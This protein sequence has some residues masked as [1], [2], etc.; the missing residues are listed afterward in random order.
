MR[1]TRSSVLSAFALALAACSS[2]PAPSPAGTAPAT[3]AAA[4]TVAPPA[5]S[6]R[7]APR[8]PVDEG[9][10]AAGERARDPFQASPVPPAPPPDDHWPRKSK[11]YSV[12]QLQLV[13]V[14]TR[15]AEPRA[16]L[17]DPK[18]K[19]W[20]VAAGDLVGRREGAASWRVDRVREREVVLVREDPES[21][22]SAMVTRVLAMRQDRPAIE[23]D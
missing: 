3:I 1:I 15:I 20:I 8:A 11:H 4:P 7:S 10:L 6:D 18:G 12:D 22:G 2:A 13:G 14:V 19:G 5:E 9:A 23:D 21:P 16:M 17:V